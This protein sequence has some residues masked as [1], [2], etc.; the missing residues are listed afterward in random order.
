MV[1]AKGTLFLFL[2]IESKKKIVTTS[3]FLKNLLLEVI[4]L[5]LDIAL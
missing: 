4:S 1:L 5:G 2:F 3:A